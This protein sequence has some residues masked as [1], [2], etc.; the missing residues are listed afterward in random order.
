MLK[1]RL[2][3]AAVLIALGV[4]FLPMLLTGEGN[5]LSGETESNVPPKPMYEIKAPNVIPLDK[6][7]TVMPV[8]EPISDELKGEPTSQFGSDSGIKSDSKSD[9]VGNE[10]DIDSAETNV[11]SDTKLATTVDTATNTTTSTVSQT[12]ATSA[13]IS[14]GKYGKLIY[15]KATTSS[16]PTQTK[17]EKSAKTKSPT[18]DKVAS[19]S[20]NKP[21]AKNKITTS[22]AM[23]AKKPIV[24]GW[25]VQLGSFSVQKNALKLRD[26]LRKKGHASFV[27]NYTRDGKTSYRVRVGPELTRE[28]AKKLKQTLKAQ[29]K[30]DGLVIAFPAK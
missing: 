8:V 10:T 20:T 27:E 14:G 12:V 29:A 11:K 18:P 13:G 22:K 1:Q 24:S 2:I 19:L 7:R 4:I 9:P 25:V 16:K 28:L 26:R 15:K 21:P 23:S 6:R 30:L 3:G 5:F 17:T